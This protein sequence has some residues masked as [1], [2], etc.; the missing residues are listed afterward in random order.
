MTANPLLL[1]GLADSG[2]DRIGTALNA[3]VDALTDL[4]PEHD[5]ED[6]MVLRMALLSINAAVAAA[7]GRGASDATIIAAAERAASALLGSIGARS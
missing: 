6:V 7:A 3:L 5:D 2:G 1:R 4:V